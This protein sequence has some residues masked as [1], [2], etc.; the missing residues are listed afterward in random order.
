MV[1][2]H[3]NTQKHKR[4]QNILQVYLGLKKFCLS[5]IHP[6]PFFFFLLPL[7]TLYTPIP[8]LSMSLLS[9]LISGGFGLFS[10]YPFR[11]FFLSCYASS[12]LNHLR[13][14][15]GSVFVWVCMDV[16][17][18]LVLRHLQYCISL[19]LKLFYFLQL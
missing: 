19:S 4:A 18:L 15:M 16:G 9:F 1:C 6:F 7:A 3:T 14:G 5:H 8:S 13:P 2:V 17:Q 10:Q 12:W 11:F